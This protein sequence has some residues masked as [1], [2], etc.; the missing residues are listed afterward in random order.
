MS[1]LAGMPST[2]TPSMEEKRAAL[3]L[4]LKSHTF[5]RAEQ[6]RS[7]LRFICEMELEGKAAEI[8]EYLIA[9]K[10]L[11]RA[12]DFSSVEDSSVR[13]MA[14]GL[15]KKLEEFYLYE[16]PE[17]ATKLELAKG[18][19]HPRF[20]R[21]ENLR[22]LPASAG[23][24]LQDG[25]QRPVETLPPKRIGY[26]R[27]SVIMFVAGALATVALTALFAGK[28]FSDTVD[29]VLR[30]AWGPIVRRDANVLI[31]IGN[32]LHMIF[33][34][35]PV[36]LP[37]AAPAYPAPSETY[38]YYRRH[39]PLPHDANLSLQTVDNSVSMG[40]V[41]GI[42]SAVKLLNAAGTS[43]QVLP[44][45]VA[46]L[47][48][49]RG[50]NVLLIGSPED[51]Q[52]VAA[53]LENMPFT[54]DFDPG[55]REIVVRDRRNNKVYAPKRDTTGHYSQV[56]GLVTVSPTEG[57]TDGSRRTIVF[58]GITSVGCH[59]AVDFMTSP[60]N[61]RLFRDRLRAEGYRSF[62]SSYQI[63]LRATTTP[64]TLLTTT[65]YET[66]AVIDKAGSK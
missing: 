51:S 11:G 15:R 4:V 52:A 14:Y 6:L 9:V 54:V 26:L 47:P 45:H 36:L 18:S 5:S 64:E 24:I 61:V 49:F 17:V 3:D 8:T 55:S 35:Y 39:R 29:P 62:P 65:E 16:Q 56:Y 48:S 25:Q 34:P 13:V 63:L 44:E 12:S 33:H 27:L 46:P 10:A 60:Q 20:V 32:P 28:S 38:S 66:H 58:S 57:T 50:R 40:H 7:F 53:L 1:Q 59:A 19:Y 22:A 31:A 41:L 2:E 23:L 21:A 42:V 43:Y 37:P 30:E